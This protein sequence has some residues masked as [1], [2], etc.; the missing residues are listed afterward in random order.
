MGFG[1][2]F[3]P[4]Y[5]SHPD[6]KRIVVCDTDEERAK[7]AS[8]QSGADEWT[9]DFH[10]LLSDSSVDAIH[11]VTPI[12]LHGKQSVA[13]LNSGKHCACTVPM[14]TSLDDIKAIIGAL[15][16]SGKYYSMMETQV[17]HRAT[18]WVKEF[19]RKG[20]FGKI[21]ML[22]GAHYQ[23]ME[24]WPSYWA[25]LPPMWY[26]THAIAPIL[27][28]A[29]CRAVRVTCLGTGYMRKELHEQYGNPF[30]METALFWLEDGRAAEA[31]RALFNSAREYSESFNVYGEDAC[32][33]WA[34]SGEEKPVLFRLSALG[35]RPGARTT[36]KELI[37]IPDYAH[38]L[39]Q[40]IGQFTQKGTDPTHRAFIHGGGHGG[41]HPHMVHDF[42]RAIIEDRK[43]YVDEIRGAD[44]TA[45]GVCAHESAMRG[46]ESVEIP[47]F[48]R[49]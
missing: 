43:P 26:G 27:D 1:A 28:I 15:E 31:T 47:S 48:G 2:E 16:K 36:T 25:G 18:L 39:P 21:Q 23:D 7:T 41:S 37:D 46:G 8:E 35:E 30:P 33:E 14:A 17:Y 5:A 34:Q 32:F 22:R 42:V 45:A 4:I 40:E 49:Y 12:P 13:V 9:T 3:A 44:W 24:N 19:A 38:L 20:G 10:S 29:G 11:L 6:V